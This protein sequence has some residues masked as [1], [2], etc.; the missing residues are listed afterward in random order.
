MYFLCSFHNLEILIEDSPAPRV[1]LK[2][3][4]HPAGPDVD[5][6]MSG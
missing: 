3:A 4:G 5:I 6:L 2:L 1:R